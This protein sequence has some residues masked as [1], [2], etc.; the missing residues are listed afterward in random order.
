MVSTRRQ[1]SNSRTRSGG[2]PP[3]KT[4]PSPEEED[5]DMEVQAAADDNIDTEESTEKE[6]AK[7]QVISEQRDEAENEAASKGMEEE[8]AAEPKRI[9]H[10]I[11]PRKGGLGLTAKTASGK[12]ELTKLIPGYTAEMTLQ[13][14]SLAGFRPSGGIHDLIRQAE[15]TDASTRNFVGKASE[16]HVDIMQRKVN[17][18][19]SAYN[20]T[21]SSFKKGIEKPKD[22]TAGKGW[23][24]MEPTP[25]SDELKADLSVIRN[26][27]YLDPKRFYKSSDKHHKIVQVGTVIEG[28]AEYYSSRLTKKQRRSNITE[29][30]L[31]DKGT[32]SWAT[33]KFKK[34]QQEKTE[35]SKQ[36]RKRGRSRR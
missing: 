3:M 4:L 6:V 30:I 36:R 34:M 28:A 31:A 14:P 7:G 13:T 17:G 15:S 20:A 33:N 10:R 27:S 21:H 24:N 8:Q 29:E 18:S 35:R 12:N 11:R 26:R 9:V 1:R 2:K 23:F 25:M 16:K 32:S 22:E 19:I 5:N